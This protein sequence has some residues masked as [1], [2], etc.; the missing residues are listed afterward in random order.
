[1][2]GN[3]TSTNASTS[4]KPISLV[5]GGN[6]PSMAVDKVEKL[7]T[8]VYELHEESSMVGPHTGSNSL[9]ERVL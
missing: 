1:M 3:K 7:N 9:S 5:S 6:Y 8:L 4:I 2:K